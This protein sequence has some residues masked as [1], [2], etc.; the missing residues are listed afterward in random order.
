[1]AAAPDFDI[2]PTGPVSKAFMERN[3]R[4]FNQATDFVRQ[5]AYYRN[6]DKGNLLTVFTDNCGTCSTKH[7]L[8]KQLADENHCEGLQL[9]VGLFR[10]NGTNTPEVS[11]TLAVNQLDYI[12]EAHCY[13][14]YKGQI[15]DY[16]KQ[17][18]DPSN[19]IEDLI[20][21]KEIAVT[22]INGY[23]VDYHRSYLITWL[24]QNGPINLSLNDIWAI[25]EQC[26]Q[27]L[28]R[29]V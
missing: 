21:E 14:M 20:E 1:M 15:L 11:A 27:D 19:F 4:T 9:M 29:T 28:A 17:G 13:L 3:I 12:P 7:A 25:R 10:M 8:L 22:Q 5:L 24:S 23:K 26:I 6:A 16:T 18:A 2:G